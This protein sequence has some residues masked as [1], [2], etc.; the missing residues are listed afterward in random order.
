MVS[1]P[2]WVIE[3]KEATKLTKLGTFL[4]ISIIN[5]K[6]ISKLPKCIHVFFSL[7]DEA[8]YSIKVHLHSRFLLITPYFG[9]NIHNLPIDHSHTFFNISLY[10]IWSKISEI[11]I[12]DLK[13]TLFNHDSWNPRLFLF[14]VHIHKT[15]NWFKMIIQ[16]HISMI[17]IK[18]HDNC[19]N[20]LKSLRSW[21]MCSWSCLCSNP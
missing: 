9:Y 10:N 8:K 19:I 15:L 13:S 17:N 6:L 12:F 1:H 4:V 5:C 20:N 3:L 11:H 7:L 2:K 16:H 14:H 18:N 21:F